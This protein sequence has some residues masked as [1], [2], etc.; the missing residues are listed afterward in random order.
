MEVAIHASGLLFFYSFVEET[1]HSLETV[2]AVVT[3]DATASG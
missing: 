2:V 3:T 1:I